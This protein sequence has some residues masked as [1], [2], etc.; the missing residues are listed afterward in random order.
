[1]KKQPTAAEQY[2]RLKADRFEAFLDASFSDEALKGVDLFEV[3]VD[4]GMVFKCRRPDT[5]FMA[6]TGQMPMAL[7]ETLIN[8]EADDANG[9]DA[10]EK[11]AAAESRYREMSPGERIA[12]LKATAQLVRYICVEP[13]LVLDAVGNR[14]NALCVNDLTQLDFK[15]LAEWASGGGDAAQGL[16]TFRRKRK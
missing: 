2:A 13:R 4:S 8:V 14:N 15:I 10:D 3:K 7:T 5:A 1:M 12:N 16:K 9:L 6:N 11:A